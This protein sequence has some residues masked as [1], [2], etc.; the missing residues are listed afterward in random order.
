MT[1]LENCTSVGVFKKCMT[2]GLMFRDPAEFLAHKP[3][4]KAN[5]SVLGANDQLLNIIATSGRVR[6]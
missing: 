3:A 2:C 4:C 5:A 6:G 1:A